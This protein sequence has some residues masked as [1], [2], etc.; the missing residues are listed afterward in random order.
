MLRPEH[1]VAM[2]E[3]YAGVSS[4]RCSCGMLE[5]Q[6]LLDGT[7]AEDVGCPLLLHELLQRRSPLPG[8]AQHLGS[9]VSFQGP[10]P[11]RLGVCYS[12]SNIS[13]DGVPKISFDSFGHSKHAGYNCQQDRWK[14]PHLFAQ[15]LL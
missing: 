5:C 15:E 9:L 12:P 11:S 14:E 7:S 3:E 10:T 13:M 4:K 2:L 6:A 1:L 8:V